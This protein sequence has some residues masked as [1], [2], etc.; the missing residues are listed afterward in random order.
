LSRGRKRA[1][2]QYDMSNIFSSQGEREKDG[3]RERAQG[4][5]RR[6]RGGERSKVEETRGR[7]KK[8]QPGKHERRQVAFPQQAERWHGRERRAV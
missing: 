1:D 8:K 7:E 4:R 5:R 3:G 2:S 6:E